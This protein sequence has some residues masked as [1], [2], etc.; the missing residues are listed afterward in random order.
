MIGYDF[1]KIYQPLNLHFTGNYDIFKYGGK[2]RT[3]TYDAFMD[4]RDRGLFDSW[5][6]RFHSKDKA[7]KFCIANFVYN[8]KTWLYEGKEQ[9]DEAALKWQRIRDAQTKVLD[10]DLKSMAGYVEA[11]T[12]PDWNSFFKFTSKGNI[13][14]LLQLELHGRISKESCIGLDSLVP[15]FSTWLPKLRADPLAEAEVILLTKYRP[16][17]T[18]DKQVVKQKLM[19]R[20]NVQK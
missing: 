8:V 7:G 4:R 16:F 6:G 20:S 3:V 13:P 11:G 12:V 10:D 2:V 17:V 14:P 19:E 9:A 15:I 1:Y 18:I 5:A